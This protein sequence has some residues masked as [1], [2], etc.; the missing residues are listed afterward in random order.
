MELSRFNRAYADVV[1]G[2]MLSILVFGA[3][4]WG[5]LTVA[6]LANKLLLHRWDVQWADFWL[7]LGITAFLSFLAVLAFPARRLIKRLSRDEGLL[8][9]IGGGR[10]GPDHP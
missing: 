5:L 10:L 6:M 4:L 9:R 3:G 2:V 1:F 7:G 8:R